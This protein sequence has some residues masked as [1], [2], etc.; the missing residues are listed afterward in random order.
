M[1]TPRE[2]K[3]PVPTVVRARV[4]R[5]GVWQFAFR[6]KDDSWETREKVLFRRDDGETWFLNGG[7]GERKPGS[8]YGGVVGGLRPG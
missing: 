3:R 2:R 1:R 6:V 5:G 7:F 8:L 4:T